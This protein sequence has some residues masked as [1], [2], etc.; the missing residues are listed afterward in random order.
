[1]KVLYLNHPEADFG[2]YGLYDGLCRVL[3]PDN[4]V[5]Y[6][7]KRSYHGEVHR[8]Q[9]E[10]P[11]AYPPGAA[12]G[13]D[14]EYSGRTGPFEWAENWPGP[15]HSEAEIR[16]LLSA[17]AFHLVVGEGPRRGTLAALR[18]LRAQLP[19]RVVLY[20]GEDHDQVLA[21][22][23]RELGIGLYLKRE[24][25]PGTAR[26]VGSCA[27]KPFTFSTV[28]AERPPERARDIDVLCVLG[29]TNPK[30]QRIRALV[31]QLGREGHQVDTARSSWPGYMDRLARSKIVVAPRGFGQDTLRRW[32][33]PAAGA[34]LV[35]ERL[36]ILDPHPLQDGVHKVDYAPDG[37]D[38]EGKI[39]HWLALDEARR[40]VARA[41]QDF[42]FQHHT[43]RARAELL[44]TWARARWPELP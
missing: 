41:G 8:Y 28:L 1:M 5:D 10:Y 44:L 29:D 3:G 16:A 24:L 7:Y 33:V 21:P 37:S 38:L 26:T 36:D 32:D 18:Q 23:I 15:E 22:L 25:F 2:G 40:Q 6:P 9:N 20:D 39:R 34:L 17:G 14:G 30:R 42:V 19:P 43:A 12:T 31:E 13:A 4:V 27:V 11:S 35:Q